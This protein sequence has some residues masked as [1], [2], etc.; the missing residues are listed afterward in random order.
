MVG[1][2]ADLAIPSKKQFFKP[3]NNEE[4]DIAI[5]TSEIGEVRLKPILRRAASL[6]P[7]TARSLARGDKT[8]RHKERPHE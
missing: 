1:P 2:Q 4:I 7:S 3:G 8:G 5:P 6:E